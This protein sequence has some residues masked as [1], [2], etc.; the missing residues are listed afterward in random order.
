[1]TAQ[2]RLARYDIKRISRI[3]YILSGD[4]RTNNL[5]DFLA[6]R[7][8]IIDQ[9]SLK[10][11]KT[12]TIYPPSPFHSLWR[13]QMELHLSTGSISILLSPPPTVPYCVAPPSK[14]YCSTTVRAFLYIY[15]L[16]RDKR[17]RRKN[18]FLLP[19]APVLACGRYS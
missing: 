18:T 5:G 19:V 8:S 7:Y 12:E 17:T 11:R 13:Q 2:L 3:F 16:C 9:L 6:V 4:L 1:V 10:N 14:I 15:S